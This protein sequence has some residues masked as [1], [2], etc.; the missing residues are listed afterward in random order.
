MYT[1]L[2]NDFGSEAVKAEKDPY[3][4]SRNI[5]KEF[6]L[7]ALGIGL[8]Y[9]LFFFSDKYYLQIKVVAMGTKVAPILATLVMAYFWLRLDEKTERKIRPEFRKDFEQQWSR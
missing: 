7:E 2:D 4:L 8:K 3:S 1:N 5:S 9:N 6:V